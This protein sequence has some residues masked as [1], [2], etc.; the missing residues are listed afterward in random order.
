M[1]RTKTAGQ[2]LG[3]LIAA[4]VLVSAAGCRS[5]HD[6]FFGPQ[7][8]MHQQQSEALVH[9]PYPATEIAPEDPSVRPRDYQRPLPEPVRNN[10]VPNS[11][12]WTNR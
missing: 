12:I 8:T 2:S 7:G 9:D 3:V 5:A 6:W 11:Q 1:R 4:A 10:I